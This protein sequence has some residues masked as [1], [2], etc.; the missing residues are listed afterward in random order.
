MD[1]LKIAHNLNFRKELNSL[2]VV[3]V[4]LNKMLEIISLLYIYTN[5]G[6]V[7][8]PLIIIFEPNPDTQYGL[9]LS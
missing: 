2:F 5:T 8:K 9:M 3:L 4:E 7:T 1:F 6:R